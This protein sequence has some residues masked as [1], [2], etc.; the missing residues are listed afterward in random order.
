MTNLKDITNNFDFKIN[1]CKYCNNIRILDTNKGHFV[2]KKRKIIKFA[3]KDKRLVK[4]YEK[5]KKT[6]YFNSK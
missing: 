1:K 6:I 2:I 3:K 5:A 4:S